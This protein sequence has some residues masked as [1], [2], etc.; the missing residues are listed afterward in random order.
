MASAPVI[1][2][3]PTRSALRYGLLDV[4]QVEGSAD[5]HWMFGGVT[6][7]VDACA[8]GSTEEDV[9]DTTT[10]RDEVSLFGEIITTGRP[11]FVYT[12]ATCRLI[13]GLANTDQAEASL[14]LSAGPQ[15]ERQFMSDLLA[16]NATDITP[17]G[18]GTNGLPLKSGLGL[19]QSYAASHYGAEPV[20]HVPRSIAEL[21]GL[22]K[23]DGRLETLL[24][25]PV[26]AGAGY[27]RPYAPG[28]AQIAAGAAF[29]WIYATGAVKIVR[30]TVDA[31]QT[32]DHVH[33]EVTVLAEQAYEP[34]V[35]CFVAGVRVA[36]PAAV[37]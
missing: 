20:L 30:S 3:A 22:V 24:G 18:T 11:L 33:N 12:M 31:R 8:T 36:L 17:A 10:V 23:A 32:I 15:V 2:A 35:D 29:T 9:C 13:G 7:E 37:G 6:A 25:S 34:L 19:L 14:A 28:G 27:E 4:A 26:V 16:P 1:V 21:L 5:T